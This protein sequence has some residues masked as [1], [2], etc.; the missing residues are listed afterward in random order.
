MLITQY[1]MYPSIRVFPSS[2]F[3]ENKLDDGCSKSDRPAPAGL[4]WPNWD[5]PVAFIPVE[6]NE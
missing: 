4:I 2:R 1:R 5:K 3:Y 6:G